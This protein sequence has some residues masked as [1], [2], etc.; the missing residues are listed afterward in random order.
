MVVVLHLNLLG[1]SDRR[2]GLSLGCH[3]EQ[4]P[5]IDSLLHHS[6]VEIVVFALKL[7]FDCCVA[8]DEPLYEVIL[9]SGE[10]V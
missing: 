4:K 2:A 8:L 10:L 5:I 1:I 6:I 7:I 3:F 9:G